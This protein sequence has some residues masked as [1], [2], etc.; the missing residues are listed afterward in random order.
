MDAPNQFFI[1]KTSLEIEWKLDQEYFRYLFN[2][3]DIKKA[4]S[5]LKKV[6][7]TVLSLPLAEYFKLLNKPGEDSFDMLGLYID[8]DTVTEEI[9][10]TIPVIMATIEIPKKGKEPK[11]QYVQL[12]DGCHRLARAYQL[13]L[14]HLP[15]VVL[16]N[17]ETKKLY[18]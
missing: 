16:D 7:H 11:K 4:K 18:C 2:C 15:C 3:F 13:G 1:F 5:I 8:W 17:K 14:T 6:S 9:D 10:L 12:I